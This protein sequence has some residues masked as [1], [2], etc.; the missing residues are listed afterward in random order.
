MDPVDAQANLRHLLNEWDP[1]G[2]ADVV[3]DE[4]DC[5]IAPLLSKL[6]A[7]GGRAEIGE[8]LWH[9]LGDHIGLSHPER[10]GTDP[11]ADRL[12]AWWAAVSR[13]D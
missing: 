10:Y 4:Y 11:M 7:G 8:F 5:M 1:L 3:A 6:A 2:V 9:E 12:V 13:N